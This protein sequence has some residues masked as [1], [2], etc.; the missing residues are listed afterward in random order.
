MAPI[1][2]AGLLLAGRNLT[3]E[4][5]EARFRG[6]VILVQI[7][8]PAYGANPALTLR[9]ATRT[10]V[11]KDDLPWVE[12][13]QGPP[14]IDYGGGF[15]ESRYQPIAADF[16]IL[17]RRV[18]GQG[19]AETFSDLLWQYELVGAR[20]WIRQAFTDL[21]DS[22]D[23]PTIFDGEISEWDDAT[24]FGIP[25]HAVTRRAWNIVVPTRRLKIEEYP[26]APPEAKDTPFPRIYGDWRARRY[27]ENA[28]TPGVLEA[29]DAGVARGA[30]PVLIIDAPTSSGLVLPEFLISDSA[31]DD[32]E[33]TDASWFMFDQQLGKLGG[34]GVA[35]LDAPSAGPATLALSNVTTRFSFV[36]IEV[37]ETT[38]TPADG[39]QELIRESKDQALRG[40]CTLDFDAGKKLG[41]WLMP[42]ISSR[43]KFVSADLIV[44][45]A[46]NAWTGTMGEARV[47]N[48]GTLNATAQAFSAGASTTFPSTPFQQATTIPIATNVL[49]DW[50]DLKQCR[51]ELE[52]KDAGQK[53]HAHRAVIRIQFQASARTERPGVK[54]QERT[55]DYY[56]ARGQR[57]TRPSPSGSELLWR[58]SNRQSSSDLFSFDHP[59]YWY[60]G[61][62]LDTDGQITGSAGTMLEH[63]VDIVHDVLRNVAGV[64]GGEIVTTTGEFGSFSDAK[65]RLASYKMVMSLAREQL[66]D[67]FL[68]TMS[69]EVLCW[70]RRRGTKI[71]SPFVAIP[72]DVGLSVDYR[73]SGD[74]FTFARTT[75]W[76]RQGSLERF[77][78]RISDVVNRVRVNF[79]WDPLTN[80]FGGHVYISDTES[81]VYVGGFVDDYVADF[82]GREAI[83]AASVARYGARERAVDLQWVVDPETATAILYRLFDLN[84]NPRVGIRFDTFVQAYDLECG[85]RIQLSDDWDSVISFP[86]PGSDGSWGGKVFTVTGLKRPKDRPVIY[87]VEAVETTT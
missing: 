28:N 49:A 52:V 3:E 38:P 66:V 20:C 79:D 48:L 53:L 42:D 12:A 36:P 6:Q 5:A 56:N 47:V 58:I 76:M 15:L 50:D 70:F 39:M 59:I 24:E 72:W 64:S 44:Y 32:S 77:R 86:G 2:G 11:D 65:T 25:M 17:D 1:I 7:E 84:V 74:P 26:N 46:K 54:R 68:Q 69:A 75:P 57:V 51:I 41:R 43:G 40:Y 81:R 80:T 27:L 34:P 60:G 78:T 16:E 29:S 67:S 18:P 87:E 31:I 14:S 22:S 13:I 73:T 85:H 33:P 19:A 4:Q 10:F 21:N 37:D 23:Y 71:G 45:F 55:S 82:A 35:T 8:V 30:L 61:G 62:T 63:P 9:L 83:A